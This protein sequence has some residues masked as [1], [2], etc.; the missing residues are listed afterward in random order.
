MFGGV[1]AAGLGWV[2]V[3][4]ERFCPWTRMAA[5]SCGAWVRHRP[6]GGHG[7]AISCKAFGASLLAFA[8]T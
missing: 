2:V 7:A 4:G 8:G 6:G 5:M 3:P 1:A